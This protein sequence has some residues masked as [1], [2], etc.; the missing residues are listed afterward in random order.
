M[1]ISPIHPQLHA[2]WRSGEHSLGHFGLDVLRHVAETMSCSGGELHQGIP[3]GGRPPLNRIPERV[4][5][6]KVFAPSCVENPEDSPSLERDHLVAAEIALDCSEDLIGIVH[7][8]F[9]EVVPPV[10]RRHHAVHR[11][12]IDTDRIES[13]QPLEEG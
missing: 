8:E 2:R 11:G 4:Q 13:C 1:Q 5:L 12:A 10:P 9:D 3:A 7:Q 6:V